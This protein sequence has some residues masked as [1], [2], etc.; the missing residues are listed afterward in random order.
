MPA[1]PFCLTS[2]TFAVELIEEIIGS[3]GY[4]SIANQEHRRPLQAKLMGKVLGFIQ[5]FLNVGIIGV[6]L[7]LIYV[8]PQILGD[9]QGLRLV[10][11]SGLGEQLL[12][13]LEIFALLVRSERKLGRRHGIIAEDRQ[14]LEDQPDF[15]IVVN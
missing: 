10:G 8:E 3:A 7:K 4:S 9:P 5:R 15:S 1:Q 11:L 13:H 2:V 14:L 12:V 6:L